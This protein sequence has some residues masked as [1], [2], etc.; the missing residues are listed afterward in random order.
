MN[1]ELI[2]AIS[3]IKASSYRKR[4]VEVINDKV[5]TPSEIAEKTGIRL[6]HVSNYLKDLK[7]NNIVKC[8]NSDTKKGRLY[9]LTELEKNAIKKI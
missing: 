6:N 4:I 1:K 7:I 2:K 8:L 3:L 9:K 5:M